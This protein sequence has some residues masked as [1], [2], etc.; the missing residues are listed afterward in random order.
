MA[1]L[2]LAACSSPS[3]SAP[4]SE[5]PSNAASEDASAGVEVSYD[6][7]VPEGWT[8]GGEGAVPDPD[9]ETVFFEIMDNRFIMPAD[10]SQEPDPAIGTSAEEFT[11]ALVARDG[12]VVSEPAD[13]TVD[14]LTGFMFDMSAEAESAGLTCV[15][16]DQSRAAPL[17]VDDGGGYV[18]MSPA[19]TSRTWVLDVPGGTNLVIW[20][21]AT[22][23]DVA[24][25]YV[26]AAT[27]VVDGL[28][29]Q[30]P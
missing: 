25:D 9:G 2:V 15:Q 24:S 1:T 13:V 20:I 29:I 12:L 22:E 6:G 16:E 28:Q 26:D 11:E 27:Q 4:S 5:E 21:L 30:V 8:S 23:P 17:W 10:C 19:E 14:G 3:E 18:V 7:D